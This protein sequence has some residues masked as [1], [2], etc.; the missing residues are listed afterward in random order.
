MTSI[1]ILILLFV[2]EIFFYIKE[3]KTAF[4]EKN[5]ITESQRKDEDLDQN[6]KN[7]NQ[8]KNLSRDTGEVNT[9]NN[10]FFNYV[11]QKY[12]KKSKYGF[13]ANHGN[14]FSKKLSV[15]GGVIY[16]V[17]YLI[18]LEGFRI[19]PQFYKTNDNSIEV[20]FYGGSF[21][22]GEGVN[23]NETLPAQFSRLSNK[24]VIVNN[25]GFHGWGPNSSLML[26]R[27]KLNNNEK[28][29]KI[30]IL[31]TLF[32][33][34]VLRTSCKPQFTINSPRYALEKSTKNKDSFVNLVGSCRQTFM[35][36][37][38]IKFLKK[39]RTFNFI[40]SK[41]Y[42]TVI[43]KKDLD[44]YYGII[45]EFIRISTQKKN[46]TIIGVIS[47]TD[48]I[49]QFKKNLKNSKNYDLVKIVD[50][51]LINLR[52]NQLDQ[53]YFIHKEDKHPSPLAHYERAKLLLRVLNF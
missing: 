31:L 34:H 23:Q 47:E 20:N 8:S 12:L 50:L 41:L 37:V 53:K 35:P 49:D 40:D 9:N 44:L 45:S 1:S 19:T 51:S 24:N 42:V 5:L 3:P 25:Y 7:K 6:L 27:D 46:I 13:L 43:E 32:P 30:N 14:F 29:I 21:T 52:N 38:F 4:F 48:S 2:I 17:K 10:V 16:N 15:D 11:G 22:F 26:L 28:K 39:S 33:E 36:E 18:N